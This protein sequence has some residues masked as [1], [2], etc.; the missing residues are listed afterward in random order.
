MLPDVSAKAFLH[1]KGKRNKKGLFN[2]FIT[3]VS[4]I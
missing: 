3:V 1:K 4:M 2:S